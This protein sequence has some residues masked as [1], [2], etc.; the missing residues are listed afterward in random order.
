MALIYN[1]A[2]DYTGLLRYGDPCCDLSR[3]QIRRMGPTQS[4]LGTDVHMSRTPETHPTWST[5]RNSHSISGMVKAVRW[6]LIRE[7]LEHASTGFRSSPLIPI[8]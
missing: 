5:A 4:I 3:V 8:F 6:I 1:T 7:T 2:I